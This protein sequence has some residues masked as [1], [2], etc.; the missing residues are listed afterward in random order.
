VLGP[1]L[2][3]SVNIGEESSRVLNPFDLEQQQGLMELTSEKIRRLLSLF[4]L[5]LSAPGMTELSVQQQ[6]LLDHVIHSLYDDATSIETLPTLSKLAKALSERA[7]KESDPDKAALLRDLACGVSL[8]VAP[9]AYSNIID[10]TTN[11][12]RALY[13]PLI[14]FNTDI[15]SSHRHESAITFALSEYIMR[16]AEAAKHRRQRIGVII[17]QS[18]RLMRSEAGIAMLED[19]S[20]RARNTGMMFLVST[21]RIQDLC[22]PTGSDSFV[23]R[24]ADTKII[25]RQ[26]KSDLQILKDS[27]HLSELSALA[28]EKLSLDNTELRYLL[29]AGHST[30]I[31][32]LEPSPLEHWICT[33]E[34]IHDV[35]KRMHAISDVQK[36][37]P[38]LSKTDACRRAVYE[39]AS[40][41]HISKS[42]R[43]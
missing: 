11:I 27:L 7:G 17:D 41:G 34:P 5:M 9:S 10:G 23:L 2:C 21:D 16:H 40:K 4:N 8:F 37:N 26:N 14:L 36:K 33:S 12:D 39:L 30:G 35:P 19:I 22:S 18:S 38:K 25:Q 31:V 1:D 32:K 15:K 13:K 24:N 29:I 6:A 42:G 43:S 3:E 28:V 20:R